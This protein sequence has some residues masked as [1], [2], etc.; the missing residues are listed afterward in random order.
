VSNQVERFERWRQR[1]TGASTL[2]VDLTLSEVVPGFVARNYGRFE[3]YAGGNNEV[4]DASCLALQRR[5]GADWPSV[6]INFEKRG[7]PLLAVHFSCLPPICFRRTGMGATEIPRIE[8]NVVEA[9]AWFRLCKGSGKNF[10]CDFG[11]RWFSLR[12]EHKI[13]SEVATLASRAVWLL[14]VLDHGIPNSWLTQGP[15]YVSEFVFRPPSLQWT[16]REWVVEGAQSRS[17]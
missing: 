14:D 2:L 12:P 7:Q 6:E 10:D 5:A 13:R 15:G 8:A 16:G 11:Y 4:V 17:G 3:D 9:P 1:L